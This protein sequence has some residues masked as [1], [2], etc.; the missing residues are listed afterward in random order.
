MFYLCFQENIYSLESLLH[1]IVRFTVLLAAVECESNNGTEEHDGT[2]N[3]S[4]NATS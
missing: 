2:D 3:D 1:G 4:G